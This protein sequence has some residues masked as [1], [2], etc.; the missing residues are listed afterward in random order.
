M[1]I[2]FPDDGVLKPLIN[3]AH[4]VRIPSDKLNPS[5]TPIPRCKACGDPLYLTGHFLFPRLGGPIRV[6][7]GKGEIVVCINCGWTWWVVP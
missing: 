2:P 1:T 5:S 6:R 7:K 4:I 3:K